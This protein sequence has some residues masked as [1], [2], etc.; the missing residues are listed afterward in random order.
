MTDYTI[1][2]KT[3]LPIE[4]DWP[5]SCEWDVFISAFNS[6]DR[7]NH[8]FKKVPSAEKH[9]LIIPDYEYKTTE[10]P[11]GRVFAPNF[12]READFILAYTNDSKLD[13]INK[14]VCVDI[15][16]F[17][18]PYMLFL[19][20]W[21]FDQK[22]RVVDVLYSEPGRYKKK[23]ETKFSDE[24]VTEVR[25]I[26][27][28]EGAHVTDTSNDLLIIGAGYDHELIAHVAESKGS[29]RKVQIFGLPS[30]R[31]D[32][33]QE[34]VL[35]AH[36]AVEAIGGEKAIGTNS[37]YAP[38]NDPF[39]TASVLQS[40]VNRESAKRTITN[41]YLC[42]VATKPQSLGFAIYYLTECLGRDVSMLY[43][44]CKSHSR[45]TSE[46]ISR[47]WQYTVEFN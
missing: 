5:V 4:Q 9:W 34:N 31:P 44:I 26:Q 10:Y 7:V 46:G 8:V 40:I 20:K 19:I 16:G 29:A 32:M 6:T 25:Q 23:E 42:S 39:V 13:V 24:D 30:L 3:Q 22:M 11:S 1:Y 43:P 18:K 2:Y 38:A 28:Y 36:R 37:F 12:N 17:I 35:R 33:Y 27:G 41:L 45:E 47:I 14:R 21:L 15:T